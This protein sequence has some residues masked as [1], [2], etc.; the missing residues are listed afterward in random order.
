MDAAK[1]LGEFQPI[2]RERPPFGMLILEP[3]S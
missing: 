1:S 3:K 2:L